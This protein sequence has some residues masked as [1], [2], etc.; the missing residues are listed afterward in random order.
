MACGAPVV[1][2]AVGGLAE[3]VIDRR[4]GRLVPPRSPAAIADALA[5]VTESRTRWRRLSQRAAV[6]GTRYGWPAVAQ[7]TMGH[8]AGLAAGEAERASRL[9]TP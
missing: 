9:V 8:L 6:R 5:W 7:A 3:T 1:A 2:S 4:T